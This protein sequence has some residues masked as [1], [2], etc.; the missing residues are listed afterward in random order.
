[1]LKNLSNGVNNENLQFIQN[2]INEF[3]KAHNIIDALIFENDSLELKVK[4]LDDAYAKAVWGFETTVIEL[5]NLKD[6]M[7]CEGCKDQKYG[8][9]LWL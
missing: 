9:N 1:M 3:N 6:S 7:S 4:K 8:F 5:N 2:M